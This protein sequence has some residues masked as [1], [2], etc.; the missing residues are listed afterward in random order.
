M[1]PMAANNSRINISSGSGP[2][3]EMPGLSPVD[4]T[5]HFWP[6]GYDDVSCPTPNHMVWGTCSF[7]GLALDHMLSSGAGSEAF[8]VFVLR[9]EKM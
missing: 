2:S 8:E 4:L 9:A 1:L 3:E 7:D 6:T 5:E